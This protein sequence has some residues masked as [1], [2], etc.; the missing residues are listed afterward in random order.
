MLHS[1]FDVAAG[2]ADQRPV[3]PV[4]AELPAMGA[5]E[6][7]HGAEGL[8]LRPAQAAAE[9]LEEQRRALGRPQH[10]HG[11]D[12]GHV[13]T[14]V[15]EINREDDANLAVGEVFQR[16]RALSRR[17]VTPHRDSRQPRPG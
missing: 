10:Q 9:L 8:A 14:L 11:V 7:E 15:E 13:D 1:A 2:A 17:A 12:R 16:R 6:V 3:A 5:D 4:E